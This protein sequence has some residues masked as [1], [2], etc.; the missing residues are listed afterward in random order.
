MTLLR[1]VPQR[2][3]LRKPRKLRVAAQMPERVAVEGRDT[4]AG[5]GREIERRRDA[6]L[7]FVRGLLG[8]RQCQ[9]TPA[10][11]ALPHQVN[12]A[13]GKGRCLT[14]TGTCQ[15]E[16][17]AF[18]SRSGALLYGIEGVQRH[19]RAVYDVIAAVRYH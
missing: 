19:D 10:I 5:S 15:N 2:E 13:A 9:N 17:D 4:H 8:E 11:D 7:H 1:C 3:V 6:G 12:E 18:G 16:L 14:R